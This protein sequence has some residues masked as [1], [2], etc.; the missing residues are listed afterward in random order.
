V[1]HGFPYHEITAGEIARHQKARGRGFIECWTVVNVDR[2]DTAMARRESPSTNRF[3]RLSA[4]M[5]GT[6]PEYADFRN[7]IISLTG[8]KV[9]YSQDKREWLEADAP[10]ALAAVSSPPR[11][12]SP[13]LSQIRVGL[14][15]TSSSGSLDSRAPSAT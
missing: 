3:Y 9:R 10:T 14:M 8:I 15:I 11:R 4:I 13:G 7:R 2:L 6:G 1:S 5:A 12:R